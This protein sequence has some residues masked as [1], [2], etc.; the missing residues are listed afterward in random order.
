MLSL[1]VASGRSETI[2]RPQIVCWPQRY[3][4]VGG[5]RHDDD[6]DDDAGDDDKKP[7]YINIFYY[8][9]YTNKWT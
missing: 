7:Y 2:E 6:D 8:F 3:V 9:Y 1:S 5:P 4:G